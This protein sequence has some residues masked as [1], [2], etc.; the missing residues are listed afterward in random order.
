VEPNPTVH[1]LLFLHIDLLRRYATPPPKKIYF[2][3]LG[4]TQT[5][6][7]CSSQLVLRSSPVGFFELIEGLVGPLWKT[8]QRGCTALSNPSIIFLFAISLILL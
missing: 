8:P 1:S 6:G 7:G 3:P 2:D 5:D 4:L